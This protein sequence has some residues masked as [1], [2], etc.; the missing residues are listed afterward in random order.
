M[1]EVQVKVLFNEI[2]QPQVKIW[3]QMKIWEPRTRTLA[4]TKNHEPHEIFGTA[5]MPH[6]AIVWDAL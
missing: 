2:E 5:E 6:W 4:E 3:K 1:P